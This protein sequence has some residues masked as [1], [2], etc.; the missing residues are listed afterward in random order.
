[1]GRERIVNR[2]LEGDGDRSPAGNVPM[3]NVSVSPTTTG[4]LAE[5]FARGSGRLRSIRRL[6]RGRRLTRNRDERAWLRR[7]HGAGGGGGAS[8]RR[9][10]GSSGVGDGRRGALEAHGRVEGSVQAAGEEGVPRR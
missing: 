9:L 10:S 1:M 4:G 5:S 8:D 7:R 6:R 3:V 2:H